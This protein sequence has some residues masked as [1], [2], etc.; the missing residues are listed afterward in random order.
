M[1]EPQTQTPSRVHVHVEYISELLV[2]T[3]KG[4]QHHVVVNKEI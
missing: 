4:Y 1:F 3:N 2:D